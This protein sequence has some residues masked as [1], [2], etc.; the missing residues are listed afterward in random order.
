MKKATKNRIVMATLGMLLTIVSAFVA[1]GLTVCIAQICTNGL[2]SPEMFGWIGLFHICG[3]YAIFT[4]APGLLIITIISIIKY[5]PIKLRILFNIV[6]ASVLSAIIMIV[7]FGFG[8]INIDTTLGLIEAGAIC[9]FI[10]IIAELLLRNKFQKTN[11][12]R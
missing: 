8:F 10:V 6:L 5:S 9:I 11:L 7:G 1:G 2:K 3:L 12:K 4:T